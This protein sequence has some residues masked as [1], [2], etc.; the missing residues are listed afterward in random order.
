MPFGANAVNGGFHRRVEEFHNHQQ[1]NRAGQQRDLDPSAAKP[2]GNGHQHQR[3][4]GFLAKSRFAPG[5]T[6]AEQGVA[7][8]VQHAA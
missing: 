1:H 7:G 8:G 2:E 5:G 4:E 6:Q 3:G